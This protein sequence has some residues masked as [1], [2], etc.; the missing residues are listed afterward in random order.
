MLWEM[1]LAQPSGRG[2]LKNTQLAELFEGFWSQRDLWI[3]V[4][5][6]TVLL[7]A[8]NAGAIVDLNRRWNSDPNYGHGILIPIIALYFVY[9]NHKRLKGLVPKPSYLGLAVVLFA[10]LLKL[11]SLPTASVVLGGIAMVVMANGLVLWVGGLRV[12]KVLWI[13]ALY[14][15]FML[16]LPAEVHTK[17][18]FPL[19][20][21]ATRTSAAVLEYIF[22]V[23]L[24]RDGN[25]IRLAS[26]DLNVVEACSG[27][28]SILGL[29]ALGVAFAY[30][31]KRNIWERALLVVS[32]L[33][34]AI[35]ANVIRIVLTGL[36]HEW[37]HPDLAEGVFHTLTGWFVFM[38]ALAM[39]LCV[40]WVLERLWVE[41]PHESSTT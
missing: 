6:L 23:G 41:E 18:A 37:G 30:L 13:P 4:I 32:A 16:P 28:R 5:T 11:I 12:Y 27:M 34:I 3:G 2:G 20:L 38:F 8:V 17:I 22:R 9:I 26:K 21:F 14:L 33:P 24:K 10:M 19:Q 35:T 1:P 25:V 39:F 31:A 29:L 15:F 36:L 7:V 40:N